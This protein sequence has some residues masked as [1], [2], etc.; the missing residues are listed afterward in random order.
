MLRRQRWR[1]LLSKGAGVAP[2]QSLRAQMGYRARSG[3]RPWSVRQPARW[4]EQTGD[5]ELP[6]EPTAAKHVGRGLRPSR[7]SQQRAGTEI[8]GG[9]RSEVHFGLVAFLECAPYAGDFQRRESVVHCVAEEEAVNAFREE[10]GDAKILAAP[11][12]NRTAEGFRRSDL[13]SGRRRR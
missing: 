1:A 10:T 11:C 8:H 5:L 12:R 13:R 2:T 6:D 3:A 9:P 4:M 7:T